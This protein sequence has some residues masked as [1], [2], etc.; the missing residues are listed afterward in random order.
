MIKIG[1]INETEMTDE[2]GRKIAIATGPRVYFRTTLSSEGNDFSHMPNHQL[3][4]LIA[5]DVAGSQNVKIFVPKS[6]S[7]EKGVRETGVIKKSPQHGI[8]Y[9]CIAG[10]TLRVIKV[11]ADFKEGSTGEKMPSKVET[12][13]MD[14]KTGLPIRVTTTVR[15]IFRQDYGQQAFPGDT[16]KTFDNAG[17][18]ELSDYIAKLANSGDPKYE[19]SNPNKPESDTSGGVLEIRSFGSNSYFVLS[20]KSDF[21]DVI[22]VQGR[23]AT[24]KIRSQ[25]GGSKMDVS[26]LG[27]S[28]RKQQHGVDRKGNPSGRR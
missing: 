7:I 18:K 26:R 19:W 10:A 11:Q 12:G 2:S 9:V 14:S 5:A 20:Q 6:S 24:P 25:L 23:F 22:S 16:T 27:K 13:V 1:E 15:R 4:E 17:I 28:P 8:F 3:D 21:L